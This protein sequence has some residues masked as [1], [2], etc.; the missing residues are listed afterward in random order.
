M[1]RVARAAKG[2]GFYLLALALALLCMWQGPWP[3]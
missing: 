2:V 1:S 3:Q